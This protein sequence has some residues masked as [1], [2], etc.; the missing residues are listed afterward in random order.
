MSGG[1]DGPKKPFSTMEKGGG[2]STA[3]KPPGF[4]GV[5]FHYHIFTKSEPTVSSR[6]LP[7][8]LGNLHIIKSTITKFMWTHWFM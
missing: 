4:N 7:L 8:R 2:S 1:V 5:G 3:F 6:I